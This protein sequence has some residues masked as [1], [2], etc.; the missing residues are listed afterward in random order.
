MNKPVSMVIK[1]VDKNLRNIVNESQLPISIIEL[2]LS[3]LL[4]EVGIVSQNQY[5]LEKRQYDN[6]LK[7][8]EENIVID[9]DDV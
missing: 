8:M 3:N 2:I 4:N 1:E 6:S 9:T 5:E 7:E